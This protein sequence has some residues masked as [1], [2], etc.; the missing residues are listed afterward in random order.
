MTDGAEL[1]LSKSS[2]EEWLR[3][4]KAWMYGYA[5]RIKGA[6]SLDMAIG[7]AV[8]AG[9]EAIWRG[10]NPAEA[11][12]RALARETA[13]IPGLTVDELQQAVTDAHAMLLTYAKH[14]VPTFGDAPSLIEA[15]FLIRVNGTLVSGRIDAANADVHDTKTTSTPSKV[16]PDHH[17]LGMT[18]YA[19]GY[20]ALTGHLPRRLLLDVVAKNGRWAVKEVEPDYAGAAEVVKLVA[21]G[22]NASDFEPTGAAKGECARCPYQAICPAARHVDAPEIM[23][24]I[25]E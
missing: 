9:A 21:D 23:E 14:I 1:I 18:L 5:Y 6:P 7:T 4:H 22:I 24:V 17:Q 20:R 25:L 13:L 8:H 19:W 16:T 2:I 10:M 15:D 3:C 12:E 11:L